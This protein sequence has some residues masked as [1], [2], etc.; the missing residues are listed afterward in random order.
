M[1]VKRMIV[2]SIRLDKSLKIPKAIC[3]SAYTETTRTRS[4]LFPESRSK[5]KYFRSVNNYALHVLNTYISYEEI[6]ILP[7]I[8]WCK[9][10]AKFAERG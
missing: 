3:V 1:F 6:P 9:N 4:P 5:Y 7:L 2:F 8:E 10:F